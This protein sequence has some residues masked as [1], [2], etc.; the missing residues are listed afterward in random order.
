MKYGNAETIGFGF[1][2][3][4]CNNLFLHNYK[5]NNILLQSE[6]AD[7]NSFGNDNFPDYTNN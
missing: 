6:S 3:L 1:K 5:Y 4:K 2:Y 7:F